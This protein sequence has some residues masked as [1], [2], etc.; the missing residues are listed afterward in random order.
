MNASRGVALITFSINHFFAARHEHSTATK[1]RAHRRRIVIT[2]D[3][4]AMP[5]GVTLRRVRAL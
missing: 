4:T 2:A 5:A 3:R 1:Q